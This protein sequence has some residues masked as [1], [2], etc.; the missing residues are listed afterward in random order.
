MP[1]PTTILPAKAFGNR[2]DPLK[3]GSA[4]SLSSVAGHHRGIQPEAGHAVERLVRDAGAG[5]G[6]VPGGGRGPGPAPGGVYHG[7]DATRSRY[8]PR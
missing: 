4:P 8:R 2:R 3:F 7:G 5:P 6:A 1:R